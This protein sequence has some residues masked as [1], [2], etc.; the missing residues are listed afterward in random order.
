M[1]LGHAV[2]AYDAALTYARHR[3]Q[4]GKPLVCFQ[5]VQEKLAIMATDLAAARLLVYR[6]AWEG[7]TG[8]VGLIFR[9]D[10]GT[11]REEAKG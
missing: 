1:A 2:G 5:I 4:F 6:A 3:Q 11:M 10:L 9:P 7:D 8:K